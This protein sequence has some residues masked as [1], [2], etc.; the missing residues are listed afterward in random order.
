MILHGPINQTQHMISILLSCM[1]AHNSRSINICD[2]DKITTQ[3]LSRVNIF[4]IDV[5]MINIYVYIYD[6]IVKNDILVW[7]IGWQQVNP[8]LGI[9]C[10]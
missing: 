4:S 9:Q 1:H 10:P 6:I 7:L 8:Y 2:I 3:K 5:F